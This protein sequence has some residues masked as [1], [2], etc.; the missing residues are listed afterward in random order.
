ME[1]LKDVT[2]IETLHDYME[3]LLNPRLMKSK[4]EL[5]YEYKDIIEQ[6]QPMDLFYLPYYQ[7]DSELSIDEIKQSAGKFVNVFYHGLT[8]HQPKSYDSLLFTYLVQEHRAIEAYLDDIKP[9]F[10]QDKIASNVDAIRT[11]LRQCIDIDK[12]YI[13]M[14]HIV[15]PMI[16]DKLPSKQPL[17]VLWSLHDD[18]R[19]TLKELLQLLEQPEID[20][21]SLIFL[22]G[23]YYNLV[24]GIHTKEELILFPVA[25]T[26]LSKEVQENLFQDC[27]EVGF[28]FL[29]DIPEIHPTKQSI[30]ING[31]IFQSLTGTLNAS[32]LGLIF[33]AI[34]LDITFVDRNDKVTFFN[35]RKERH[36]PRT[37]SIIGRLVHHCHP[38]KSVHIVEE[39]LQAFKDGT[40]DQAEFWIDFGGTFLYITYYALRDEQGSYQGTLEVSQDVT[41]IR[42]LEG[43]KR[44][45]E[46]T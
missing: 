39:I 18:A 38:K 16:E 11:H 26:F 33:K 7:E 43:Q 24:Y 4:S 14:E 13:K 1:Y 2:H 8:E 20:M 23:E 10:K 42:T 5:Y 21:T 34:P 6:V 46:W 40:K 22:I 25:N 35:N 44:L 19:S 17:D 9:L 41:K 30:G 28:A 31:G 29:E 27:L 3:Q 12:V 32:Q 15:F 37:P 36:F 45:L